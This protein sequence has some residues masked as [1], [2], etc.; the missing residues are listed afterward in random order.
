MA[1]R[2]APA[3]VEIIAIIEGINFIYD[4]AQKAEI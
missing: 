3:F 4:K 1:S 2:S